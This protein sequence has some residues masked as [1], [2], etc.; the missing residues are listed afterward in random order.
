MRVSKKEDFTEVLKMIAPM[1]PFI[2][3]VGVRCFFCDF[4]MVEG[5]ESR[6]VWLRAWKMSTLG[7]LKSEPI[8]KVKNV[9]FV[10]KPLTIDTP[11][12]PPASNRGEEADNG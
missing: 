9:R 3:D 11:S 1:N 4:L 7:E 8:A 5:H 6:C 12:I 2:Y 10:Y